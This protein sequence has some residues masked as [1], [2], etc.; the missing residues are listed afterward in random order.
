[1]A[2]QPEQTPRHSSSPGIPREITSLEQIQVKLVEAL[3]EMQKD[4]DSPIRNL[5]DSIK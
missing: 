1:M 5:R 4:S 3:H 2:P